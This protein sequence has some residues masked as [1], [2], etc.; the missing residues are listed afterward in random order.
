MKRAIYRIP[1]AVVAAYAEIGV[2]LKDK[3]LTTP[4]SETLQELHSLVENADS[5]NVRKLGQGQLDIIRQRVMRNYLESDDAKKIAQTDG[6]E[7]LLEAAQKEGDEYVYGARQQG[8]GAATVA[9]Q[10]KGAVESIFEAIDPNDT[11]KIERLRKLIGDKAVDAL[12]ATR[13]S[14]EEVAAKAAEKKGNGSEAPASA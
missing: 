12:L 7:K 13:K 1:A 10:A 8:T 3:T 4:E 9:R 5:E 2:D 14:A 6:V 11:A